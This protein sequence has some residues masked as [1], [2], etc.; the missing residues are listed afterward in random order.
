MNRTVLAAAALAAAGCSFAPRYQRPDAGVPAEFRLA[1][2]GE[3]TSIADLPWWQVFKDPALQGLIREALAANQDL[4]VATARV[5]EARALVGVARADLFPQISAQAAAGYGQPVSDSAA[6]SL[7]QREA[8]ARYALD[9][10]LSWELDLW[11]RV[12]NGRDAAIADL[13][14]TEGG[15]HAV[16]LSLVSGVAQAYLELRALDLELEIARSNTETR[17]GTLQLFEARAKGGVASDLEVNQARA[18]LA[19]TQAAIPD[20]EMRIWRKEHEL[21]VLLGRAPGAIPR[22]AAL[23][24]T[25][26][27]PELPSGVPAALLQRRPDVLAAEQGVVAAGKRVGV[28]VANRLPAL[29][30][31]G[32][33]GLQARS[34][35]DVFDPASVAWNTGG[36]L[37]API[38]QGGRLKAEEKAA[39][40]RLEASVASYRR[41]VEEALR[42][43]ADASAGVTKL[44]DVRS[45]RQTQVTATTQAAKL[46]M[47]RYQGGVSSYLE[48]LDAQRQQFDAQLA[49]ANAA[50]DELTSMVLLYRALGGG[51]QQ[52]EAAEPARAEP[53]QPAPAPPPAKTPAR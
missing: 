39:R 26:L 34:A 1:K 25:P 30:L 17:K 21:C 4:A 6:E 48:V 24:E 11:G 27:V 52:Q 32:F 22:G 40:A 42:E 23:V 2:P 7:G 12:R 46:A 50:R 37:L 14:A 13:L 15:R 8:R 47:A 31:S 45:A 35:A 44:R 53:A 38:F 43:V 41:A 18:D 9:A 19:V 49:L 29:S 33:I 3:A 20:T 10:G 16:V 36:S 28:A 5:A 51:W